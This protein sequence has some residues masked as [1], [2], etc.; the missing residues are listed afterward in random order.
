MANMQCYISLR[1]TFNN[2]TYYS[3]FIVII[4]LS[5]NHQ[6]SYLSS[7]IFQVLTLYQIGHFQTSSPIQ[8]DVFQFCLLCPLL[9]RNFYFDVIPIICFCFH[10]PCFRR[11]IQKNV[12]VTNVRKITASAVIQDFY[13]FRSHTFRS[14]I[15]FEFIF[16]V[17][18]E[19][20]VQFHS[21]ACS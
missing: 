20:V 13:G 14:L 19:E 12:A 8:Q 5:G 3:V 18:C 10:F 16:C 17:W 2:S 11:H 4:I 1:C 9:Y 15:H 6:L 21:F 7:Y